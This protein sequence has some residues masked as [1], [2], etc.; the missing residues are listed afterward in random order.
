MRLG[1][2]GKFGTE[3][4]YLEEEDAEEESA[5]HRRRDE[6]PG[7]PLFPDFRPPYIHR[8]PWRGG[9]SPLRRQGR[10]KKGEIPKYQNGPPTLKRAVPVFFVTLLVENSTA[11]SAARNC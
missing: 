11:L 2:W 7:R 4:D 9:A 6:E 3:G 8:A 5:L 10:G 1:R